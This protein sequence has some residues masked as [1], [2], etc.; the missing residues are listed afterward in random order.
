MAVAAVAHQL[1]KDAPRV[2]HAALNKSEPLLMG[3]HNQ[4]LF[5]HAREAATLSH[6]KQE[7]IAQA[8]RF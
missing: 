5:L 7:K 6:R 1:V 2:P 8:L 4:I 3:G